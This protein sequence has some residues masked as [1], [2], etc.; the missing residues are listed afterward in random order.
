MNLQH[1]ILLVLTFIST[2]IL[3]SCGTPVSTPVPTP[4]ALNELVAS[5]DANGD[6]SVTL[7]ATVVG[8]A[9]A[10]NLSTAAVSPVSPV[11]LEIDA[12]TPKGVPFKALLLGLNEADLEKGFSGELRL[13]AK[14]TELNGQPLIAGFASFTSETTADAKFPGFAFLATKEGMLLEGPDLGSVYNL[15]GIAKARSLCHNESIYGAA[16]F[17][18]R[19]ESVRVVKAFLAH[20]NAFPACEEGQPL[21]AEVQMNV[22]A[23]VVQT[24]IGKVLSSYGTLKVKRGESIFTLP[25]F[26][27]G[28]AEKLSDNSIQK[29]FSGQ[30]PE[31][32]FVF[33][34]FVAS[35]LIDVRKG[36]LYFRE[37]PESF[38]TLSAGD[39]IVSRPYARIP[40]G[41]FRK[42]LSVRTN[43]N[44]VAIATE[45]AALTS[46][47][48]EGEFV[49]DRPLTDEDIT[50]IVPLVDGIDVSSFSLNSRHLS[51]QAI[52]PFDTTISLIPGV[53]AHIDLDLSLNPVVSF[54][55][56]G[57]LCS[58]P[59]IVGK[60]VIDQSATV[61]LTGEG[62]F[63][64][65]KDI[66]L[67][68]LNFAPITV[69]VPP[70]PIVIVPSLVVSLE[71]SGDGTATITTK[72]TQELEIE[73][74]L[75]KPSGEPWEKIND[76]EKSFVFDPPTFSGSVEAEARLAAAFEAA[77]WGILG[78][79]V[80]I[81]PYVN[82]N[83][84][85]PGEPAWE[86]TGGISSYAYFFIDLVVLRDETDFQIFERSWSIAEGENQAPEVL[87]LSFE[88][89]KAIN[90][91]EIVHAKDAPVTTSVDIFDPEEGAECCTV[92]WVVTG[93]AG[94]GDTF[95]GESAA[96]PHSFTFTPTAEGDYRVSVSTTDEAGLSSAPKVE[97]ISVG[98]FDIEIGNTLPSLTLD[99]LTVGQPTPGQPVL[100]EAITTL[101][102][103]EE[104]CELS[105][106]V[107]GVE[108]DL[109]SGE[110][111]SFSTSWLMTGLHTVEVR[112]EVPELAL[113]YISRKRTVVVQRDPI[114][115]P[116][117]NW[118]GIDRAELEVDESFIFIWDVADDAT[119]PCCEVELKQLTP[120][121]IPDIILY[122]TTSDT[123]W[124]GAGYRY[125]HPFSFETV[126][127]KEILLTV[128][129]EE[130]NM[131]EMLLSINVE[132]GSGLP[133]GEIPLFP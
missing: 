48:T 81:G 28:V 54:K 4:D 99:K 43:E 8:S 30:A 78:A 125:Y 97:N 47:L 66:E 27:L 112:L 115:P 34:P 122:R 86:L 82:L 53:T 41:L 119:D 23:E 6:L 65:Q 35:E 45:Q 55:C 24:H 56:K 75:Q 118:F 100:F 123:T 40:E 22:E 20:Q 9:V 1:K 116:E 129:D 126:G 37:L 57:A 102:T 61:E 107:D 72:V 10:D 7:S 51:T 60:V 74:G 117:I 46:L 80:D 83:V 85:Y 26:T 110:T 101:E 103:D 29:R 71:L 67:F 120:A 64:N 79:G 111:H 76:I 58:K 63:S 2:L 133:T 104:C 108:T 13:R 95:V 17:K 39:F 121:A 94:S 50:D 70:I 91:T 109:T 130:D 33:D 19:V 15:D 93:P 128:R 5:V 21:N 87:A 132:G 88:G 38:E 105:W 3:T 32:M 114:N 62:N 73:A 131:T 14:K 84:N 89:T 31:G 77:L 127:E 16:L 96:A 106:F 12:A 49:F 113:G 124:T 36:T 92:T 90:V 68:K 18:N 42:V 44:G 59:E 11:L 52:S 69:A 98:E 25:L